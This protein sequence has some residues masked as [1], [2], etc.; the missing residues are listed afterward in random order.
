MTIEV[1][2]VLLLA[3]AIASS[4]VTAIVYL[5]KWIRALVD[6]ERQALLKRAEDAES[7]LDEAQDAIREL[8]AKRLQDSRE[9]GEAVQGQAHRIVQAIRA[10]TAWS[11][12]RR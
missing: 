8:E 6:R 11:T 5:V 9:Y 1:A 12:R 4:L 7:Q 10:L 2:K 3:A